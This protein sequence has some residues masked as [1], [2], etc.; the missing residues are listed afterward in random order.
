MRSASSASKRE[1]ERKSERG[2]AHHTGFQGTVPGN[3]KHSLLSM[4]TNVFQI[5]DQ[6]REILLCKHCANFLSL[7]DRDQR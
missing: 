1:N 3:I 5:F 2:T 6:G 4:V 7:T